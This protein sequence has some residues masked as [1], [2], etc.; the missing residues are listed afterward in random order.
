MRCMHHSTRATFRALMRAHVQTA[1]SGSPHVRVER[2]RR[3]LSR[4][5]ESPEQ[6][7]RDHRCANVKS[8]SQ[9]RETVL[10]IGGGH[11]IGA[12]RLGSYELVFPTPCCLG[13]ATAHCR[14]AVGDA[15]QP[16][17]IGI[18]ASDCRADRGACRFLRRTCARR[19]YQ[20]GLRRKWQY[21]LAVQR[22]LC[23]I[24][25]YGIECGRNRWMGNHVHLR[26]GQLRWFAVHASTGDVDSAGRLPV[27]PD[28]RGRRDRRGP[29]P[30][31][32]R[33]PRD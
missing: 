8:D 13:T 3:C 24:A 5:T 23:R 4:S 33:K 9:K 15:A 16:E 11:L 31:S 1:A 27:D 20:S 18:V 2:S 19:P 26:H 22:R 29:Q 28:V 6:N 12:S 25:Q 21:R 14:L 10:S 7:F 17:C 32:R 30:R